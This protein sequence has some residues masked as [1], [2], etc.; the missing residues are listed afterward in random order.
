M[1]SARDGHVV[2][3]GGATFRERHRAALDASVSG[4]GISDPSPGA[5]AASEQDRL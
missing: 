1:S 5:S 4:C 2:A 3:I